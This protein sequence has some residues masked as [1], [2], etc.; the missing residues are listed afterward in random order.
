M[1]SCSDENEY[2]ALV[3][4][5]DK[6]KKRRRVL[7]SAEH[8]RKRRWRRKQL[9]NCFFK[10]PF[11]TAN[12]V[13]TPKVKSEPKFPKSVLNGFTQ[14]VA[15]D[16]DRTTLGDLD[17]LDDIS[18]N[19][20]KFNSEK[21]RISELSQVVK[22]KRNVSQPGPNQIPY[23]V[24]KKCPRIMNYIFRIMLIAVRDKVIPLN[25]RVSDGIM[26]PE[27]QNPRKPNLADYRQV[28]LGNVEGKLFW[29]LIAQ[30][31]YQHLGSIQKMAG[32]EHTL[33]FWAA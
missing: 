19:I 2:G 5:M 26:I 20:G 16:P 29:S 25:W 30:R 13:T 24:Y 10:D 28:V 3:C 22:K 11:K 4:L 17:G 33:I 6:L 9:Q 8:S 14:K 31:F 27:V 21:F 15:S 18:M 7:R 12:E 23:K 32:W 1:K